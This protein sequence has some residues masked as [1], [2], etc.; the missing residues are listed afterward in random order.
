MC[1]HFP[2]LGMC[3][4]SLNPRIANRRRA[5]CAEACIRHGQHA[6]LH[7]LRPSWSASSGSALRRRC[8]S[9]AFAAIG[10]TVP[11]DTNCQPA[12]TWRMSALPVVPPPRR[13][14]VFDQNESRRVR[15]VTQ[16]AAVPYLANIASQHSAPCIHRDVKSTRRKSALLRGRAGGGATAASGG[17][18]SAAGR[19][20]LPA[21]A[22][23]AQRSV[24]SREMR[25]RQLQLVSAPRF[26]A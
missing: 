13:R 15:C 6:H 24:A 23:S 14:N 21:H 8:P 12:G 9:D 2:F 25:A 26:C 17:D 16:A 7:R 19:G 22:A 20:C 3:F 5:R 1:E 11:A 10:T 4:C 18:G